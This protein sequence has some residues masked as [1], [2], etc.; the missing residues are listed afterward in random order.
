M[1]TAQIAALTTT[2]VQGLTGTEAVGL[3]PTQLAALATSQIPAL[4]SGAIAGLT[5][6]EL[7]ALTTP[8][9]TALTS[10]QIA[11]LTTTQVVAISTSQLDNLNSTNLQALID[12][13]IGDEAARYTIEKISDEPANTQALAQVPDTVFQNL[14]LGRDVESF[15]KSGTFQLRLKNKE[16]I[17]EAWTEMRAG[18]APAPAA[19]K[20]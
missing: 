9:L 10:S 6:T 1:T 11:A 8:Q 15:L 20:K 4:S 18:V 19:P 16:K 3:A 13:S 5:T 14:H 12:S 2:Q 17:V 7:R